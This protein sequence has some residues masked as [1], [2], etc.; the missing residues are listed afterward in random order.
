M[1]VRAAALRT[2]RSTGDDYRGLPPN[3][4]EP[5]RVRCAL[6]PPNREASHSLALIFTRRARVRYQQNNEEKLEDTA[7][8]SPLQGARL[9]CTYSCNA[10][11]DGDGRMAA[12]CGT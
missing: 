6:L 10:G 9:S 2:Y 7:L 1:R 5:R 11:D 4:A 3:C 12:A 8:L